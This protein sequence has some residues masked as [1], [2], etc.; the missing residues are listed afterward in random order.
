MTK[1]L[2][3]TWWGRTVDGEDSRQG[4]VGM[5]FVVVVGLLES[6]ET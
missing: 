6:S 5:F 3:S 4:I 1:P 2:S